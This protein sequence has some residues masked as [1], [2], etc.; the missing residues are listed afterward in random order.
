MNQN[1]VQ[2]R[3]CASKGFTLIELL[4]VVLIIGIL[5]AV[6]VSQYQVAVAKARYSELMVLVKHIKEA[7]EVYYLTN[8][9]YAA[10][11]EELGVD[12]PE[13]TK[14]NASKIIEDLNGK[15]TIRCAN[16]VEDGGIRVAGV[17]S[18]NASYEQFLNYATDENGDLVSY[19]MQCW[20]ANSA[21]K[22]SL[23][24]KICKSYCGELTPDTWG[25]YCRL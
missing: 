10:D 1:A 18:E 20:V 21:P 17:L 12:L 6:A 15:F 25:L 14:L 19:H 3:F 5:A 23:Y 24:R 2:S 9:H 13:G 11:C 16:G 4:V 8:G 7:Q 22:A